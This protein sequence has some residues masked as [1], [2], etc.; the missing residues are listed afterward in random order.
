[1]TKDDGNKVDETLLLVRGSKNATK[2]ENKE[3]IKKLSNAVLKVIY[4][5]GMAS[6][7]CVGAGSMNNADKAF[8]IAKG[9]SQKR[10]DK[11]LMDMNFVTVDFDGDEKTGILKEVIKVE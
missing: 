2:E 5:H 11:L 3:Y 8:I 6:M 10:G 7:R 1:M 4:K 9:E